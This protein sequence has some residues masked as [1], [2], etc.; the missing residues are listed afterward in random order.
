MLIKQISVFLE[1]RKGKLVEITDIL[2]SNNI[3]IRALCVADTADYGVLRMIVSDTGHAERVLRAENVVVSINSMVS[4]SLPDEPGGLS[5]VLHVLA[6]NDLQI[7]YTYA[8]VTHETGRAFVLM[9]I[10]EDMKARDVLTKAGF[11]GVEGIN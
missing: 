11:V 3:N 6:D 7:E 4:V 2:A 10:E 5:K 8:F 9:R 1:N